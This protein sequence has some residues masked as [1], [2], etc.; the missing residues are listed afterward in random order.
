VQNYGLA[1]QYDPH[2]DFS[3]DLANS[4]LGSLGTGNRIATVLVWMSQ[5][6][7]GGATVFPYVGARILPQKV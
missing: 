1:G 6:E 7:S 3:R 4:S 5:V 2:F